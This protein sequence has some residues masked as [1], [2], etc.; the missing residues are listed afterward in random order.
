MPKKFLTPIR[1]VNLASDPGSASDGDLYYNT[2]VDKLKVYANSTWTEVGA[3]GGGG[4]SVTISDTAP[5]SPSLGDLWFESDTLK[6]YIYYDSTWVEVSG[7]GGTINPTPVTIQTD[8][9]L[10]NSWWLGV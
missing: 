3:G 7:G 9:A 2:V 4:S 5:T 8:V 10:S 6:L 1:I